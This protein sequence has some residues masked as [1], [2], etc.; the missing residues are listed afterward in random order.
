MGAG[1]GRAHLNDVAR[2]G[3]HF[4]FNKMAQVLVIF[5]QGCDLILKRLP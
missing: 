5:L 1:S 2:T 4:F 3:R